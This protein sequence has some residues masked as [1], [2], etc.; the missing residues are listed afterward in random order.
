MNFNTVKQ[1][2][3]KKIK[4][5]SK[6]DFIKFIDELKRIYYKAHRCEVEV[7]QGKKR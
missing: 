6:E 1:E 2:L 7:W 5:M 4:K 3:Y